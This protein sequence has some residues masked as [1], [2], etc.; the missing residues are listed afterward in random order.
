VISSSCFVAINNKSGSLGTIIFSLLLQAIR[1]ED[2]NL[3]ILLDFVPL[4]IHRL[5]L[6]A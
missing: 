5:G 6:L 2:D 4:H 1:A 3:A